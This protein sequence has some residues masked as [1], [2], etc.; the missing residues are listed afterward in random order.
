MSFW[1]AHAVGRCIG[2]AACG[3]QS[4]HQPVEPHGKADAGSFGAAYGFAQAVV[5]SAAEQCVL[6]TQASVRELERGAGV[7]IQAAH[8][9]RIQLYGTP[10]A[11]SAAITAA[12]CFLRFLVELI[13]DLGQR[14]DDGLVF[15]HL[16]IQ[17]AQRV[18]DG[19]PL[20]VLAHAWRYRVQNGTQ[21]VV[22]AGAVCGGA[23]GVEFERPAGDAE[24]VSRLANISN[25]SASRR[26]L[27]LPAK[28]GPMT[29]AP[30]CQN[31][32]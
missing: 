29:S 16:A 21:G 18:G 12:K 2:C 23:Y 26:G 19:A 32:R 8:Q 25:T 30:I 13:G 4:E 11:S 5:A 10:A 7:V 15:G 24:L 27:S 14:L 6:R 3:L 20:A 28:G 1:L 22:I 31:W 17:H 9:P